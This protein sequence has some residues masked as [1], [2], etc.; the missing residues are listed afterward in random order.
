MAFQRILFQC[1]RVLNMEMFVCVKSEHAELEV[2]CFSEQ[3]VNLGWNSRF[4]SY[5]GFVGK[6]H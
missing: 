3:G 6:K 5:L 1:N 2:L 4:L